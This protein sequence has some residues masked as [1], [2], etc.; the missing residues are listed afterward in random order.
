MYDLIFPPM[1]SDISKY[2]AL[3]K[4][5]HTPNFTTFFTDIV[6]II[7]TNHMPYNFLFRKISNNTLILYNLTKSHYLQRITTVLVRFSIV[8][9]CIKFSTKFSG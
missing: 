5:L 4:F 9:P 6:R 7:A 2:T 3:Q 1:Y 8:S